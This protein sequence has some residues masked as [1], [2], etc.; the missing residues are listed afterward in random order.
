MAT[1]I[2]QGRVAIVTTGTAVAL[3]SAQ[4]V[5][6]LVVKA[7]E[8]NSRPLVVGSSTVTRSEATTDGP[9][10]E[11]GKTMKLDGCDLADVYV[12]GVAGDSVF[13]VGASTD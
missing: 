12:N 4:E 13:Y 3:G 9:R 7:E 6:W 5:N 10:L 8:H 1:S 2:H 11:A